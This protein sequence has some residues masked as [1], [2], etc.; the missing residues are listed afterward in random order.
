MF[1]QSLA[2]TGSSRCVLVLV[3]DWGNVVTERLIFWARRFGQEFTVLFFSGAFPTNGEL[4][5]DRTGDRQLGT[6]LILLGDIQELQARNCIGL[7]GRNTL[8]QVQLCRGV[9]R[10]RTRMEP[11]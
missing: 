4:R 10:L 6:A 9:I 11:R 2:D 5:C 3:L 8:K 7:E 1:V